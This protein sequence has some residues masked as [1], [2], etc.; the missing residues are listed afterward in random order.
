MISQT[1]DEIIE[2]LRAL[3]EAQ[4]ANATEIR[5]VV[6]KAVASGVTW[7]RAAEALGMSRCETLFRQVKA[8]SPVIIVKPYHRQRK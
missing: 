2:E 7:C 4:R 1:N 8:G 5:D 3:G 6:L